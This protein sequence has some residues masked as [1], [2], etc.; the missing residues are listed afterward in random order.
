MVILVSDEPQIKNIHSA[1][2]RQ[3]F[4]A[5]LILIVIWLALNLG[6][7]YLPFLNE[8]I[9]K[10]LFVI[11]FILIIPGYCLIAAL[12]PKNDDISLSERIALSIGLSIAVVPLM[13]LALNP[14]WDP[15]GSFRDI[16]NG[17]Y[18]GDDPGCSLPERSSPP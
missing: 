1:F 18:P 17:I 8:T 10:P 7:I 12:F 13:G 3:E 2:F 4:P 9:V 14:V 15:P 5:D 11:P 16:I 6:V